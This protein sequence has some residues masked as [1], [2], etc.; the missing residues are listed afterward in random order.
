MSH[1]LSNAVWRGSRP[2]LAGVVLLA[3]F[4]LGSRSPVVAPVMEAEALGVP[5]A[6][7]VRRG[8]AVGIDGWR[9]EV[10]GV[11]V[12]RVAIE[13]RLKAAADVRELRLDRLALYADSIGRHAVEA[14]IDWRLVAAVIAEE[15][16]FDPNA[17][18]PAGA[19][20]LMQVKEE[21]ARDVGVFP[22]SDADSNIRAGVRYL[23]WMRELFAGATPRDH[24]A[25]MLAAYNMG[26][27]HLRDAIALAADLGYS[28][29]TWDDELASA[30]LMMEQPA[31][32]EKL[33]H[34]YAQGRQVI[35][36]VDK[37]LERYSDYRRQFPAVTMP[38][39]VMVA[40][41]I[42]HDS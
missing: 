20:G 16:G 33:R 37:V 42:P 12:S 26:P 8:W 4:A 9:I 18:S 19:F 17:L 7:D 13:P 24:Q 3:L 14:G 1:A 38:S 34:G 6:R 5:T 10:D 36:Y 40:E 29:R 30:V 35:R 11:D 31:V 15:S 25:M 32:H 28:T 41:M 23:A 27:G 39:L 2:S 21:A 22:Y